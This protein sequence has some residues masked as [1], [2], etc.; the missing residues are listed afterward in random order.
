MLQVMR[1]GL[2]CD[3]FYATRQVNATFNKETSPR[4]KESVQRGYE[5]EKRVLNADFDPLPDFNV[6]RLVMDVEF[7][8]ADD[9]TETSEPMPPVTSAPTAPAV[10][11]A[12]IRPYVPAPFT[13]A[14]LAPEVTLP[15]MEPMETV[16]LSPTAAPKARCMT[17]NPSRSTRDAPRSLISHCGQRV[18]CCT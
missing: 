10:T 18:G 6:K 2:V 12:P 5:L 17:L 4:F 16:S 11:L 9:A 8:C 1:V 15:P 14:P 13:S 7:A 3:M